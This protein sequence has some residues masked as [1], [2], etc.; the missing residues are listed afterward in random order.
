MWFSLYLTL[1]RDW[2]SIICKF[3]SSHC[4]VHTYITTYVIQTVTPLLSGFANSGDSHSR[5]SKFR[6]KWVFMYTCKNV[7]A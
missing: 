6:L 5:T 1:Q 4:Y 2:G 7:C 3:V